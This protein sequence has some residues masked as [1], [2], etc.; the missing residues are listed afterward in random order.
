[1]DGQ[2]LERIL[3][4]KTRDERESLLPDLAIQQRRPTPKILFTKGGKEGEGGILRRFH[5]VAKPSGVVVAGPE[6]LQDNPR[7]LCAAPLS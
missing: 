2:L 5:A 1:M 6:N 3:L 4:R 7:A